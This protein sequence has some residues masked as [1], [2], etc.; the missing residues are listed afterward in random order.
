M[1]YFAAILVCVSLA[2]LSVCKCIH[3]QMLEKYLP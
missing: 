1:N 3:V 2:Y